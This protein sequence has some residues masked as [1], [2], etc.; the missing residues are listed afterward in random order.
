[1]SNEK[2]KYK[3]IDH[4]NN[5]LVKV[6]WVGFIIFKHIDDS[7]WLTFEMCL[8]LLFLGSWVVEHVHKKWSSPTRMYEYVNV[9]L[10]HINRAYK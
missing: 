1:M 10:F 2:H 5:S 9:R 8:S 4:S 3:F 6:E 7:I